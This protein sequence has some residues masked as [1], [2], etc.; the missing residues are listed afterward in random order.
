MGVTQ[1][2]ADPE[3]IRRLIEETEEPTLLEGFDWTSDSL[4]PGPDWRKEVDR[5]LA[6][7]ERWLRIAIGFFA[8]SAVCAFLNLLIQL[9]L[10]P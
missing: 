10:I 1:I 5:H 3:A 2:K 8:L 4:R 9:G 6:K 7:A